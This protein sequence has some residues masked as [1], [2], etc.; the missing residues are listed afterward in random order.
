MAPRHSRPERLRGAD[1][2]RRHS[3]PLRRGQQLPPNA[4][5]T[6]S[7]AARRRAQRPGKNERLFNANLF[8]YI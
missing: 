2:R 7:A 6:R 4:R 3:P 1:S 8:G 5:A